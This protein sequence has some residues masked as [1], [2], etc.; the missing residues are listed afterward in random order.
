MSFLSGYVYYILAALMVL[1][2]LC[3]AP[4]LFRDRETIDN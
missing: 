4:R 2:I 1:D 3:I